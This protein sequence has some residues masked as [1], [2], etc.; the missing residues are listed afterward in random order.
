MDQL[1]LSRQLIKRISSKYTPTDMEIMDIFKIGME[2]V[3]LRFLLSANKNGV[4]K[5]N[6]SYNLYELNKFCN[7]WID[8]KFK[9][10]AERNS[11]SHYF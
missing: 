11:F 9:R 6:D 8:E 4:C 10:A 3:F 1:E 7:E 2:E 5:L